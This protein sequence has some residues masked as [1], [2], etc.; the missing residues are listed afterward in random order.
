VSKPVDN[1]ELLNE[2]G[3]S[4]Y[5]IVDIDRFRVF[6]CERSTRIII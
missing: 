5:N 2:L 3:F 6:Y 4:C 1:P